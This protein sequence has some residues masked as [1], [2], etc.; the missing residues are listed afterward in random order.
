MN[1]K[2]K[3]IEGLEQGSLSLLRT[4]PKTDLH[5]HAFFGTKRY[6]IEKW[7]KCE[8]AEPAKNFR[9]LEE[10]G[11]YATSSFVP[12]ISSR[13]GVE[14]VFASAIEDAIDDGVQILEMSIDARVIMLYNS[15]A[16]DM[17]SL[18]RKLKSKYK[19]QISFLP[20]LG[21]SRD[22]KLEEIESS[23]TECIESGFF[24]SIDLYGCEDAQP[25][26]KYK[27]IYKRA[28]SANM[29]LKAHVGEFGTAKS[30]R[31][32]VEL[33][34][35]DNVQHGIKAVDSQ[36]TMNWLATNKIQLNICPTSNVMLSRVSEMKYHPI[37]TLF[38]NGIPVTI[39]SDDLSIF[40]QSVSEEYLNLFKAGVFSAK[41]LEQIRRNAI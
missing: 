9:T 25:C 22:H 21:I 28:K 40:N 19:D 16:S 1:N 36:E 32:T 26:E 33:L 5:N 14:F 10:M 20:E 27:Q 2:N 24:H 11:E 15:F 30:I 35:L 7:A 41:E 6:N 37:R 4:V 39:N 13:E 31:K 12:Y 8:I 23:I 3:F 34:E 18:L 17:I 29:K 38:D